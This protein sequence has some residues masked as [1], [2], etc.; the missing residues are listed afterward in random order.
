MQK[1]TTY[2]FDNGS[3]RLF[4]A[5]WLLNSTTYT[6][7]GL[8]AADNSGTLQNKEDYGDD[9]IFLDADSNINLSIKSKIQNVV[10]DLKA[11]EFISDENV[12][13]T[14]IT[15][16]NRNVGIIFYDDV[17]IVNNYFT[18]KWNDEIIYDSTGNKS[19]GIINQL[20]FNDTGKGFYRLNLVINSSITADELNNNSLLFSIY[21]FAGNEFIF[22][23]NAY[24]ASIGNENP[25]S[26]INIPLSKL[27][28]LVISFTDIQPSDMT[29]DDTR[30]TCTVVIYNPNPSLY[31]FPIKYKL[32]SDSIGKI[33]G[34]EIVTNSEYPTAIGY[35]VKL[36]ITDI[37]EPGYVRV[38]SWVDTGYGT[39]SKEIAKMTLNEGM[40]EGFCKLEGR[41]INLKPYVPNYL[42]DEDFYDFVQNIELT[43]NSMYK[44][45]SNKN[46][47]SVLE[48]IARIGD[49]NDIDK[50]ETPYLGLYKNQYGT[51]L[52]F[53]RDTISNIYDGEKTLTDSDINDMIRYIYKH[54][55]QLN[56]Y[57]GSNQGVEMTFKMFGLCVRL[58]NKWLK[59]R[60]EDGTL[61]DW[62]I[63]ATRVS[64]REDEIE[65]T[66]NYFLTSRFDLDVSN[67]SLTIKQF[68]SG[69]DNL[70]KIILSI[71]P[72]TR[73]FDKFVYLIEI[74]D[75]KH[76]NFDGYY[77]NTDEL[78][79]IAGGANSFSIIY[80]NKSNYIK[81]D[82]DS[83]Y[84]DFNGNTA[85]AISKSLCPDGYVNNYDISMGMKL[86]LNESIGCFLDY[87]DISELKFH[88]SFDDINLTPKTGDIIVKPYKYELLVDDGYTYRFYFRKSEYD[89]AQQ[90]NQINGYLMT[91]L[92]TNLVISI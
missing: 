58:V 22:D 2:T 52:D 17:G 54:T 14:A 48:K 21:D 69:I 42:K 1:N 62:D 67:Q 87:N 18:I 44:S 30:G 63:L 13:Y 35:M 27:K 92:N 71:K 41:K 83:Y 76:I 64:E 10:I 51:E 81:V 6:V 36:F 33:S 74:Q 9:T 40:L 65:N 12:E 46:N 49:F 38:Q 78:S 60:K 80:L 57:K 70:V 45:L 34:Y 24:N 5:D 55:P 8:D 43:L 37:D 66:V 4:D 16:M 56:Q 89:K 73:V 85:F 23:L 3:K 50:I 47:I 82:N 90:Q 31:G 75:E 15:N 26:T 7:D 91:L 84:Y 79:S 53:D 88:T 59:Y 72:L 68:T 19:N 11:P 61:E 28:P 32:M 39:T 77:G 29:I 86:I 25:W 20:S